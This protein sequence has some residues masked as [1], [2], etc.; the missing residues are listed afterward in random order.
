[1]RIDPDKL[2]RVGRKVTEPAQAP[3]VKPTELEAATGP[4]A[5]AQADQVVL[6][7]RAA[8]IQTA[9]EAV[10]AMPEVRQEKVAAIKKRIEEGTYQID[11]EAIADKI[12]SGTA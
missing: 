6:S 10:A 2:S 7:Q 3:T 5:P 11:P 8:E 9:Q 4:S 12:I 1:M